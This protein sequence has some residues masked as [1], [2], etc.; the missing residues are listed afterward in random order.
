VN[1]TIT[2]FGYPD[3]LIRE[4][5]HWV[6][7][8]RQK[9]VTLGC[10]ILACKGEATAFPD[11][12]EAAF[13]EL[14]QVTAE[15]EGALKRAF[16]FERVNYLILMMVDP[17]VH[18]HVIPRYSAPRSFA[19]VEFPDRGWPKHPDMLG[20]TELPGNQFDALRDHLKAAWAGRG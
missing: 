9:Q 2:K 20:A 5:E 10:L 15:V 19:G 7:L 13:A 1:S 12:P 11:I 6:V 4:Y 14:K 17:H 16:A 3:T 18:F 8:L